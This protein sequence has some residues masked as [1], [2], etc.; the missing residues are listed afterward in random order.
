MDPVQPLADDGTIERVTI[1]RGGAGS[2]PPL[3]GEHHFGIEIFAIEGRAQ[4][5][6][7]FLHLE[8]LFTDGIHLR[9]EFHDDSLHGRNDKSLG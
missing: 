1:E 2:D 3:F 9:P 5:Q 7:I 4:V 6:E 8:L